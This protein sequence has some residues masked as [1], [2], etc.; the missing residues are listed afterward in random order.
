M[1]AM[2]LAGR[3][4]GR[5]AGRSLFRHSGWDALLVLLAAAQ[6]AL[7]V[8]LAPPAPVIAV[9][10]WWN[11]NTIS[12]YFIHQPFFRPR[13]LNLL[14]SFYLTALLGIP[15]SLWRARH[16]AHHAGTK[17]VLRWSGVLFAELILIGGVWTAL[18]AL[19]PGF[20]LAAYLPG[21]LGGLLIGW[22]HGHYEHAGGT[23]SHYGRLYNFLFLNDGYHLEH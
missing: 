15:Q 17:P 23:T 12:H 18:L 9:L 16:L 8:L 5:E 22:L 10:V 21:L 19:A 6:V 20:F 1:T 7:L 11:S 13:P 4:G 2:A 14:F 3:R